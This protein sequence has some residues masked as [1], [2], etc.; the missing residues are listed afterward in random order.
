MSEDDILD[1]LKEF[2]KEN[3]QNIRN[4]LQLRK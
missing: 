4:I 1:V 2:I 3:D